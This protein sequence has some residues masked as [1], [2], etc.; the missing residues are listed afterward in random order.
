[1]ENPLDE[2]QIFECF[3]NLA[4]NENFEL[5]W[6][7]KLFYSEKIEPRGAILN[8]YPSINKPN[9]TMVVRH[10]KV[11]NNKI[12]T[13]NIWSGPGSQ[14]SL[15]N[16]IKKI[17][18]YFESLCGDVNTLNDLKKN[19]PRNEKLILNGENPCETNNW[20]K[21]EHLIKNIKSDFDESKRAIVDYLL[22]F[23]EFLKLVSVKDLKIPA[24][25]VSLKDTI[26]NYVTFGDGILANP[27]LL[28]LSSGFFRRY[29]EETGLDYLFERV[30]CDT[31]PDI[32]KMIIRNLL[33]YLLEIRE[34]KEELKYKLCLKLASVASKREEFDKFARAA[35][36][37]EAEILR[38]YCDEIQRSTE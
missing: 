32:L 30:G 21:G 25:P 14:S 36:E 15:F 29:S 23:Q 35:E 17:Y 28:G 9:A 24:P 19:F 37:Y 8:M 38:G 22:S 18:R 10:L 6:T 13:S 12:S 26:F 2:S 27:Y 3:N 31:Q 7:Q 34:L 11:I 16:S 33:S 20:V 5:C 1:M 4:L